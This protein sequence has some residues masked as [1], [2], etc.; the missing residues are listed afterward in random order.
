MLSQNMASSR[1]LSLSYSLTW[2][3]E[4]FLEHVGLKDPLSLDDFFFLANL[5]PQVIVHCSGASYDKIFSKVSADHQCFH[6]H[7]WLGSHRTNLS[8]HPYADA[9]HPSMG[10]MMRLVSHSSHNSDWCAVA[11]VC[12]PNFTQVVAPLEFV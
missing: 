1:C 7:T 10:P 4:P 12:R 9:N 5:T 11:P 3:L 6:W 2:H 8:N